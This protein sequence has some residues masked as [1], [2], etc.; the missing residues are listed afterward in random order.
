[1][2][3]THI[4]N[5]DAFKIINEATSY[6]L[7]LLYADGSLYRR[8]FKYKTK[9]Q[10]ERY[11]SCQYLELGLSDKDVIEKYAELLNLSDYI[12]VHKQR[13]FRGYKRKT[14]YR[15]TIT[16]KEVIADLQKLGLSENKSE[17]ELIPK[18]PPKFYPHFIRGIF[19]GDG[20]ISSG[21]RVEMCLTGDIVLWVSNILN[22]NKFSHR[23]YD[24]YRSKK[25]NF[26]LKAI[27]FRT[28]DLNSIK[29]LDW[30]YTDASI[31][32][33]RKYNIYLQQKK[34]HECKTPKE[35]I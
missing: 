10:E 14:L 7:G 34:D 19:D 16:N 6:F 17:N 15:V 35:L 11:C 21:Q 29:F 9:S 31:Y 3:Q 28:K 26:I 30:L 32:M 5:Q 1:M 4:I 25:R 27:V 8:T 24:K 2:R 12:T 18:I 33:Q 23:I 22:Q 20:C 13:P